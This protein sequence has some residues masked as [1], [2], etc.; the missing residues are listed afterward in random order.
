MT[1]RRLLGIEESATLRISSIAGELARQGKDVVNLSLGEPDFPT[2]PH[3]S[4]A[5]KDAIDRGET[6]YSPSA[7]IPSLKKAI[8]DKLSGENGL[9]AKPGNIIVTPGAKQAIFETVLAILDEG[10][11]AILYDPAWVTYDACIKLAGARTKWVRT[12]DGFEPVELSGHVTGKTKLIIINSP[13]NPTGAVYGRESLEMVADIAR[14][15]GI[16]VLSD[17]IYE[18]IIYDREHLSIG[19]FDGMSDLTI[20][21]NG[22]SKAYAMTGWRL[23]YV[24]APKGVYEQML[25]LHSHSVSQATSFVQYAGLAALQGDQG[26]IASMVK[27][28]RARR[29]LLIK[30]LNELGIKCAMPDGAFYAFADVSGYGSGE[31]V[32]ELL[33]NK[34][35]VAAT[36][37]AAFGEAG[38]DFIRISYATS[39]ERI[40]EALRRMKTVL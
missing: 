2:P 39:Q 12:E 38:N 31:E 21:V 6:H 18:K 36:P 4:A 1:A 19:S 16:Y 14:D 23:G 20:T 22:F 15:K 30:G 29:D 35:F 40:R 3:I 37:G 34:A 7:G 11:E 28:F 13:C 27:E 32:A 26:C 33:L 5:A 24:H 17:E 25:K 8:A 10:D 9:D